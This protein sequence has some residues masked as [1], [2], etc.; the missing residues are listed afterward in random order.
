MN[1]TYEIADFRLVDHETLH[2]SF[3]LVINGSIIIRNC[4]LLYSPKMEKHN[5]AFPYKTYRNSKTGKD[6]T[7]SLV[8]LGKIHYKNALKAALEEYEKETGKRVS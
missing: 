7:F 2:A 6:S 5:L 4:T 3:S 8:N 1:Y